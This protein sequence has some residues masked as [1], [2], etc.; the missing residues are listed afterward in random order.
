MTDTRACEHRL[1]GTNDPKNPDGSP[2]WIGNAVN[3]AQVDA[4]KVC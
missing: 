3:R 4:A 2:V 1:I